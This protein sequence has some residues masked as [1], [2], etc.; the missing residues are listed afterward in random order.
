MDQSQQGEVLF[1]EIQWYQPR[2][3]WVLVLGVA[4]LDWYFGFAHG[5]L[6]NPMRHG[7]YTI[8]LVILG[9]LA[10]LFLCTYR[11]LTEVRRDGIHVTR[12]P[13]PR[14]STVIRFSQFYRYQ[15]R[16]C[17]PIYAAGGWGIS[18]GWQGQAFNMG[19]PNAV[20][21]CLV[22]GG[23]VLIGSC[24]QRQLLDTLHHLCQPKRTS[25]ST[26]SAIS[27]S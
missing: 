4:A 17:S 2:W 21:L 13:F 25:A 8:S 1:R 11:Q 3:L 9:V 10:P 23:R 19:G 20:E 15:P 14:S 5:L 18:Q 27:V 24:K 12:S 7:L 6:H 16:V 22:G 26:E